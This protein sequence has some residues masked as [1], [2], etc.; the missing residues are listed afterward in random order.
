MNHS[1]DLDLDLDLD[2]N[3]DLDLRCTGKGETWICQRPAI[4]A[5]ARI[6]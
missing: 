4:D 1:L 3:L 6:S 2:V 5:A